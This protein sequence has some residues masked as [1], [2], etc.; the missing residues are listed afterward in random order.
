MNER[1]QLP[2]A[3]AL[4]IGIALAGWWVADGL[5]DLRVGDRYVTVKGLAEREVPAD[6]IIWPLGFTEAGN[7]L[8]QLYDVLAG[9]ARVLKAFLVTAGVAESDIAVATPVVQDLQAQQYGENRSPFRY[10]A[11]LTLTVRSRD[12]KSVRAAM[13]RIG[14]VVKQ[15]IALK[16]QDWEQRTT[17]LFTGLNDIKPQLIAEATQNAR[18]AAEQFAQDSQSEVGQIRTASQ[19]QITINDREGS[20]EIKLVRVV[21][22]VEYALKD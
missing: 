22:T 3:V 5:R 7:D 9:K 4:A 14:E 10:R 13:D 12:L 6:L 18:R 15:G 17:Y 8:P 2:A 1:M 16:Q 19:G 21:S 20:P 11:D